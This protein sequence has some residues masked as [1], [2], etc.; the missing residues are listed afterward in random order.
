M[1]PELVDL[2]SGAKAYKIQVPYLATIVD[3]VACIAHR[4][5]IM[6]KPMPVTRDECFQYLIEAVSNDA[7]N[8]EWSDDYDFDEIEKRV[9]FLFP[10][11]T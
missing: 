4:T 11:L 8:R 6:G 2:V 10:E 9:K 1:K 5:V 7:N 3:F